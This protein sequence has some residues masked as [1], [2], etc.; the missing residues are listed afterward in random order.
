[1]GAAKTWVRR[2]ESPVQ[3][4]G[5]EGSFVDVLRVAGG[6]SRWGGPV[7]GSLSDTRCPGRHC[8]IHIHSFICVS[9]TMTALE[10]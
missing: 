4:V 6:A 1:M 5:D 9:V 10:Q 8:S 3:R 7:F 2:R